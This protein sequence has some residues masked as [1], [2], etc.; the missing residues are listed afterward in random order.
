M[1]A[2]SNA[3]TFR[4]PLG[5]AVG[6]EHPR[7]TT[8]LGMAG[9][10]ER[11]A[12]PDGNMLMADADRE[13]VIAVLHA[14]V[15]EGRITLS[16][17]EERAAAVLAARTF[18]EVA[19]FT[20]DLPSPPAPPSTRP[21]TVRGSSLRR[22]GRWT[23][24]ARMQVEAHGSGVRLDFTDAIILTPVV[25]LEFYL[26]GSGVRLTVP[27]GSTI[28]MSHVSLTGS[29]VHHR[30]VSS[31]PAPGRTHFVV[32]GEARGSSIRARHPRR[33]RWWWP[34]RRQ[35]STA[36]PGAMRP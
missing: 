36:L 25:E 23:V 13:K 21:I 15:T 20:R 14:A 11:G 35:R 5:R 3:G 34:W 9:E 10:I 12:G 32:Y 6:R 30:G 8:L 7:R 18:G 22:E 4:P 31:D 26:R 16:E 33:S 1:R 19:P 24:P 2:P 17:F 29:A 27:D 28:D